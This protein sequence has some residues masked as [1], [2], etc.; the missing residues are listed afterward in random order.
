MKCSR[1]KSEPFPGTV[2]G[3]QVRLF[4]GNRFLGTVSL[5]ES[6]KNSS[7]PTKRCRTSKPPLDNRTAHCVQPDF[8]F[9]LLLIRNFDNQNKSRRHKQT[10]VR[11]AYYLGCDSV[12]PIGE[13]EREFLEEQ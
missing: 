6:E 8:F 2:F 7:S 10:A 11:A 3:E 4:H 9:S 5:F 13:R 1:P 12:A